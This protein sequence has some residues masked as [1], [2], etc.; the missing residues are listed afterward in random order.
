MSNRGHLMA[1]SRHGVNRADHGPLMK[2][3]FEE[4]VE[5]LMEAA[6][7]GQVDHCRG[8]SENLILGQLPNIGTNEFD[9][10]VDTNCLQEAKPT[11]EKPRP[12]TEDA[13]DAFNKDIQDRFHDLQTPINFMDDYTDDSY[14]RVKNDSEAKREREKAMASF[15]A[16]DEDVDRRGSG[17]IN[18]AEIHQRPGA[19]VG[20]NPALSPEPEG[21]DDSPLS[22]FADSVSG[23]F[24]FGGGLS[25]AASDPGMSGHARGSSLAGTAARR[26]NLPGQ[27]SL[28][29]ANL[30]DHLSQD[31]LSSRSQSR[32]GRSQ[33]RARNRGLRAADDDIALGSGNEDGAGSDSGLYSPV[34]GVGDGSQPL[35]SA[36]DRPSSQQRRPRPNAPGEGSSA[37]G[38]GG[39]GQGRYTA[40]NY[41]Q[42]DETGSD[43]GYT[44][45]PGPGTERSQ[46]RSRRDRG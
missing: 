42:P 25:S 18:Y 3:S 8:V 5:M 35:R 38:F 11:Y 34:P 7:F 26:A 32:V 29:G 4:T 45:A 9:I 41:L 39:F 14:R 22:P 44:P 28:T 46:S 23:G 19:S 21:F 12:P 24:H 13:A 6:M 1:I 15:G 40:S 10:L 30:A 17:G 27:G 37:Y 36:Y 43:A 2:C 16:M 20:I 31:G 33:V